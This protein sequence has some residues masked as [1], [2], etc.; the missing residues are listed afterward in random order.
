MLQDPDHRGMSRALLTD[1][2]RAAFEGEGNE[3]QL[4]TYRS[5]VRQRIPAL[6]ADLDLVREHEPELYAQLLEGIAPADP[7]GRIEMAA[8][9]LD[10]PLEVE[11]D[12]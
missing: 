10:A 4:S 5:R 11:G 8:M 3:N 6:A 7:E 1:A 2:E 9:L 12:G